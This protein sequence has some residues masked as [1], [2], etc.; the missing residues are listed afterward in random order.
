MQPN[1]EELPDSLFYEQWRKN[2]CEEKLINTY[3]NF[4][5]SNVYQQAFSDQS[6]NNQNQNYQYMLI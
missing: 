6:N 3:I 4:S 2:L 1:L 5:T